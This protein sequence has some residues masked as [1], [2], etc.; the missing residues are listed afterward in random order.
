M[1]GL[2]AVALI[3]LAGAAFGGEAGLPALDFRVVERIELACRIGVEKAESEEEAL[4]SLR[5]RN[6]ALAAVA[7]ISYQATLTWLSER[8]DLSAVLESGQGAWLD[9][10]EAMPKSSREDLERVAE[11]LHRRLAV[12]MTVTEGSLSP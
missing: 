10:L 4:A 5:W 7:E 2:I 9:D 6:G 8:P 12:F 11:F 1:R 3:C